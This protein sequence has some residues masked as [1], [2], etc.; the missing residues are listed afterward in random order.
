MKVAD[1]L[2]VTLHF[3]ECL[4]L[5]LNIS[6]EKTIAIGKPVHQSSTVH[7]RGADRAVD[8]NFSTCSQTNSESMQ[9]WQVDLGVEV[10]VTKVRTHMK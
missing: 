5:N 2:H 3:R 10:E 7:G 1:V 9:W 6:V 4:P 8:G